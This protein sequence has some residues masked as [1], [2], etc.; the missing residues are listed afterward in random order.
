MDFMLLIKTQ[1]GKAPYS[2]IFV[3]LLG[4]SLFEEGGGGV[5]GL[6]RNVAEIN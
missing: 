3:C 5:G 6:M 2:I 1:N 4:L